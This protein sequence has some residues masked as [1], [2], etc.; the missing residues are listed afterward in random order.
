MEPRPPRA[1]DQFTYTAVPTVIAVSP[2][3]GPL[4]GA[5]GVTITGTNFTGATAVDFGTGQAGTNVTVVSSSEITVNAPAESAATVD[6][7]VTT[8]VGTSP[9]SSAD[10]FTYTAAPTVTVVSPSSGPGA[11]GTSVTVTGSNL[12]NATAVKFGTTAGTVTADGAGL[13]HGDLAGR[14]GNAGHH[15]HH[16]R[17]HLGHLG[18]RPVHL[19]TGTDGH[20]VSPNAGPLGGT[21]GVTITGT[22]LTGATAVDFGTGQAGTDATVVSPSEITVNAPAESAATVDV[23]V[24]TPGGTSAISSADHFT[25]TAAPTVTAVSP[26]AGPLG[27]TTGVTITGTNFTGATAVDFGT[28]Q[29][30]TNV[31]VVSSSEITVN[32]PAES[33]A[34]VDVTVTTPGGTS[35][36]SSADHF[37]YT[38]VPTVTVVSP[39]LR[40][41]RWRHQ[42]HRSRV[43]TWRTRTAVKFGTTAGTVTADGADSITV[44]S[45]AG[46]G[47]QD[48]TV[49]TAGGTSATSGADQF[50]YIPAPTSHSRQP[51]RRT[52]GWR[53]QRHGDGRQPGERHRGQVRDHG[54]TVTADGADS[55]TVTSPAW[56]G[57]GRRDCHNAWW[58]LGHLERRPVQLPAERVRRNATGRRVFRQPHRYRHR[59][60]PRFAFAHYGE[61][62]RG[63][64]T[65]G[66]P[67]FEQPD[68]R[69]SLGRYRR[70]LRRRAG[71][72]ERLLLRDHHGVRARHRWPVDLVVDRIR[73]GAVLEPDIQ[74]VDR[75]RYRH[76]QQQHVAD[77]GPAD[78]DPDRR[79]PPRVGRWLLVR[80]FR[81][82]DLLLR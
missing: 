55:I 60:S 32:A 44:T 62:F 38:A 71:N 5:T 61:R 10:H 46:T 68:E 6:V 76:R 1:H 66:C 77:V 33:A 65:H 31:T 41:R 50:T 14:H 52:G 53:H 30:G 45:P 48:I 56:H 43:P 7:T 26:N 59:R 2:N 4:G 13:H 19:H 54:G 22:N 57:N 74:L 34:T 79:D 58:H 28:G 12:A 27:G 80:R 39:T 73:M 20:D 29:A 69:G 8:P 9:T 78:G 23:T 70:V 16:G 3:A 64:S 75:V 72:W 51:E 67:V 47:T 11:G 37:T 82:G 81:R 21:T 24:T 35:A 36:T 25:Y 18:R 40:S 42:R 63:R 15:G 49:T 17:W